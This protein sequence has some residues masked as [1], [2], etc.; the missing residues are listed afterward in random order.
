MYNATV[1]KI[2]TVTGPSIVITSVL[3]IVVSGILISGL[4]CIGIYREIP[5]VLDPIYYILRKLTDSLEIKD[6]AV[7]DIKRTS[8]LQ[9]PDFNTW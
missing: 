3:F 7:E 1:L 5:K 6:G 4:H 2:L 8:T 9:S